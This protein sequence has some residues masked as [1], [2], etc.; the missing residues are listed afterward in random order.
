MIWRTGG[1]EEGM[2]EGSSEDS[3][4]FLARSNRR[5]EELNVTKI[6]E[7]NHPFPFYPLR[8]GV[9]ACKLNSQHTE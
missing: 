8:S 3:F 5:R 4:G 6:E 2:E 7:E 1:L 9:E